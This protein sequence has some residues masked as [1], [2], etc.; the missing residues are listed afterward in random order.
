[1]S[2]VHRSL[3]LYYG[4]WHWLWAHWT[5]LPN[6]WD[7]PS[8]DLNC[9]KLGMGFVAPGIRDLQSEWHFEHALHSW[10]SYIL[11]LP[12]RA[13]SMARSPEIKKEQ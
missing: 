6:H 3:L 13:E 7:L 2:L 8:S 4:Q 11:P 1:M 9:S 12:L 5:C 10:V